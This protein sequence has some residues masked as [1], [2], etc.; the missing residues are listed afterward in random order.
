VSAKDN[1]LS[2]VCSPETSNATA[3]EREISGIHTRLQEDARSVGINDSLK[4]TLNE[5]QRE[6]NSMKAL[7]ASS[8]QIRSICPVPQLYLPATQ[9][10]PM[11][12]LISSA[13]DSGQISLMSHE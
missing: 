8:C 7:P 13:T 3:E 2:T 11:R 4:W 10:Y 12:L 9:M 6:I 1:F 5:I